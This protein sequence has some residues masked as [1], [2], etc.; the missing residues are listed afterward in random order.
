MCV[1][2]QLP[3]D[4]ERRDEDDPGT[5]VGSEPAGEIER[6]LRLLPSSSGTTIVR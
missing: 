1:E 2:R 6:V 4:H 5:A 3:L